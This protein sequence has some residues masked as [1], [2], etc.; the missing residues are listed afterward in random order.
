MNAKSVNKE[1]PDYSV[2]IEKCKKLWEFYGKKIADEEAKYTAYL[3]KDSPAS[4]VTRELDR[5]RN[6]ELR[7]LQKEYAHLFMEE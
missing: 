6:E 7:S 5:K 4:A 3:G 2:Y 1:H